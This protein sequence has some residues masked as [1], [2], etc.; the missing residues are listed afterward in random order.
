MSRIQ[1]FNYNEK[2]RDYICSDIHGHFYLLEDKL[3]SVN[4]NKSLDR[5]FCLGD[6][7]DRSDD[8][9]LVL[10]YLKEPWFYSI[11][12]NHEIM[13]IDACEEDNPDVKRQWY[14]W[15][16]DWAEDLSDE[17]LDIYYQAISRLPVA[18]ELE[19]KSAKKIALV[20]ANLPDVAD[21]DEMKVF[22]E[23]L[24]DVNLNTHLPLLRTMLWNKA[25]VYEHRSAGIEPV[26]NIEHV[27]H[28][29]SIVKEI[30]VLENR[31]FMDLGSYQ[32]FNIGF[33][34]PDAYLDEFRLE[35]ISA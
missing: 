10:D 35:K 1:Y 2:G 31:T 23:S 30:V 12:G 32:Y 17:E 22:L 29:H 4:F 8:S 15:G 25:P 6:L 5:L 3:K 11:I 13:L 33:I 18:I 34:Q 27:F 24:P 7:I 28:G 26:K 14:F 16:G 9:V 20:H 21:W 19:L